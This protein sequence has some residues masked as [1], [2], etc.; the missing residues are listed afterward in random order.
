MCFKKRFLFGE[1]AQKIVGANI[2]AQIK[3][4]SALK[5]KIKP[6]FSEKCK[7]QAR[8]LYFFLGKSYALSAF[9]NFCEK[10]C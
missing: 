9:G 7:Q 1:K 2:K 4:E 5:S 3:P 8:F 10:S 6:V